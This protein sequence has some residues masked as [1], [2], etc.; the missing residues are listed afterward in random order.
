MT[1]KCTIKNIFYKIKYY[2]KFLFWN[3]LFDTKW[4]ELNIK[5]LNIL[6]GL[7]MKAIINFSYLNNVIEIFY[8]RYEKNNYPFQQVNKTIYRFII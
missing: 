7:P 6:I 5:I 8:M 2:T 1:R 3:T 4:G